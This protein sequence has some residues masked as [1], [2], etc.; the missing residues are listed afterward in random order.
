MLM[1]IPPVRVGGAWLSA[2]VVLSSSRATLANAT[3]APAVALDVLPEIV[4]L[5]ILTAIL[6]PGP[7]RSTASLYRC[8]PPLRVTSLP[9]A[10][11]ASFSEI[12]ERS[13]RNDLAVPSNPPP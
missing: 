6:S 1:M 3:I 4:E 10:S 11:K 7:C 8:N 12:S 9:V 13:I 2:T 5:T